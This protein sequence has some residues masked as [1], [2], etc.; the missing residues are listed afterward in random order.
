MLEVS[1]ELNKIHPELQTIE[2]LNSRKRFFD[3]KMTS[4]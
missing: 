2:S 1:T 3:C 4:N